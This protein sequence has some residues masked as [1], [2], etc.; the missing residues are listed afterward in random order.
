MRHARNPILHAAVALLCGTA[1]IFLS[2]AHAQIPTFDNGPPLLSTGTDRALANLIKDLQSALKDE[3]STTSTTWAKLPKSDRAS[4]VLRRAAL[5]LAIRSDELGTKGNHHALAA[6]IFTDAAANTTEL[7]NLVARVDESLIDHAAKELDAPWPEDPAALSAELRRRLGIFITGDESTLTWNGATVAPAT[8]PTG[9]EALDR[10]VRDVESAF[11]PTLPLAAFA[12]ARNHT[13]ALLTRACQHAKGDTGLST[14]SLTIF[15]ARF[16]AILNDLRQSPLDSSD[17]NTLVHSADLIATLFPSSKNQPKPPASDPLST[18]S[19][20]ERDAITRFALSSGPQSMTPD[21]IDTART[22]LATM[23]HLA[24]S[25]GKPRSMPPPL[26]QLDKV[27]TSRALAAAKDGTKGFADL[28]RTQTSPRDP[29]ILAALSA[30]RKASADLDSLEDLRALFSTNDSKGDTWDPQ[31]PLAAARFTKLGVEFQNPAKRD[32][33]LNTLRSWASGTN[34]STIT[35]TTSTT[36]QPRDPSCI[37]TLQR[38]T[39][40]AAT[41]QDRKKSL[42]NQKSDP[43]SSTLTSLDQQVTDLRALALD[44]RHAAR[45]IDLP[46]PFAQ[47]RAEFTRVPGL[48]LSKPAADELLSRLRIT[49][50]SADALLD[51]WAKNTPPSRAQ[52]QQLRDELS[53]TAAIGRSLPIRAITT[54]THPLQSTLCCTPP[55]QADRAAALSTLCRAIEA[56][57]AAQKNKDA[58]ATPL[59]TL[60]R[61]AA[62]RVETEEDKQLD[63]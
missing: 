40:L 45:Y 46:L 25:A 8:T 59:L 31:F 19:A 48:Y 37:A 43:P 22:W 27:I 35:S 39:T 9:V 28:F 57:I 11:I 62:A 58:N 17:L 12:P 7:A 52:L 56:H 5:A 6:R 30:M 60:A 21:R 41:L 16:T 51:A 18:L 33:A 50:T 47:R 3:P 49:F 44:L 24:A 29:A 10:A 61:S 55:D 14:S 23:S 13:R 32:A 4:L 42:L 53:L 2:V 38:V 15:H 1:P 34:A 36:T 54:S 26:K 63:K 20:A